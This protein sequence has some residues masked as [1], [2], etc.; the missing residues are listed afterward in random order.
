MNTI[1]IPTDFSSSAD[2]AM[3]Y[4]A[5]LAKHL[6]L[7]VTLLNVYQIPVSINDMP[8]MLIS[9]DE[10]KKSS[11]DGLTRCKDELK[12]SYIDLA[13]T[14]E[15]RLGDVN[16]ELNELC[17]EV[18]PFVI[19][20]G[21]HN[22]SGLERVLLGTTTISVIRHTKYPVIA[23]PPDVTSF[24]LN[25]VSLATDLVEVD[26]LPHQKIIDVVSTLNAPLTIVHIERDNEEVDAKAA[27]NLC[28]SLQ[29]LQP[30]YLSVK[31]DKVVHGLNKYIDENHPDMIITIP[32]KHNFFE[33]FFFRTNSEN[34]LN[35][36]PLPIMFML[37]NKA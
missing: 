13:I 16:D 5:K 19:V 27:Q 17:N 30:K 22:V 29:S 15:S 20:M 26:N 35:H 2:N 4:G 14:I 18:K 11:D 3:H 24:S 34:V 36:V 23:V 9:A 7:T 28:N 8:V 1:I 31:D 37:E 32:H 10:L 33:R 25:N 12:R 21:S 6:N